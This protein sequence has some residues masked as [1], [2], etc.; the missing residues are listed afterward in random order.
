MLHPRSV[1]VVGAS[2]R[3]ESLNSRPLRYLVEHGYAGEVFP[4]NPNHHELQGLRCF[5]DLEAVPG[6][7]DLVLVM[8]P[9][10]STPEIVRQAGKIGAAGVVIYGSGF[11]EVGPAGEELQ[12]EL[13]RAARESGVR[14][15]GPNCQGLI[16]GPTGMT[17][18]FTMAADRPLHGKGGVAYVGQSGA[19]GGSVLDLA[20]EMGLGLTAW[21][22]TGNQADLD[23]VEMAAALIEDSAVQVIMMYA[24]VIADG[25]AY[26]N[27]ARQVQRAGK[28]L[29][30]LLSGRSEAGRRA[31]A[32]HTGSMLGD[33][34]GFVLTSQRYGVTLVDD[35]DELLAI[36]ATIAGVRDMQGRRVGVIT[37][38][39]G[40]GSLAADHCAAH[41]LELPQLNEK[42]QKQLEPLV[43]DFGALANPVDV[44]AQLFNREGS[45]RALGEVCSIVAEDPETDLVAVI[46]T[47]VTGELG[48]QLAED[49]TTTAATLDKPLLVTWLAGQ[50]QTVEGRAVFRAHGMPVFSSVGDLARAAGLLA[51][52]S[53]WTPPA[54]TAA[55]LA[56]EAIVDALRACIDGR[57]SGEETLDALGVSRPGAIATTNGDQARKAATE[58]VG[59]VAMK[60][61]AGSLAHKSDLGGVR[62]RVTPEE[63]SEVFDELMAVAAHHHVADIDGVLVQEMIPPGVELIVGVTS[64]ADGYAPVVTVG[65]GGVTTE[66]YRDVVSALAPVSVHE[67]DALL[68]ELKAWPLLEGF[69]GGPAHDVHAAAEAVASISRAAAGLSDQQFEFEINPLIVAEA[70]GGAHAVDLLARTS[71]SRA[72]DP[73]KSKHITRGRS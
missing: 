5:P 29:V 10:Q 47:M 39:G 38:S 20:T 15:L 19:V 50:D 48:R 65:M 71:S 51:P 58:L 45:A 8:V 41:D 40:A 54:V 57:A 18:T 17:A 36:A 68:R 14:V 56:S 25:A 4:I 72:S 12:E 22:S 9:A 64:A 69:R 43:P 66:L 62:L 67:A 7:V 1:A 33:D 13:L 55:S 31:A 2:G 24:E 35:V 23:L 27:L 28:H 52:S 32:S 26:T 16:Y 61:Q 42:T 63:A 53:R 46:L 70:G 3:P 6:P 44:T 11:A 30:V 34:V 49:L 59:P 60:L 21:V 37:T 73:T